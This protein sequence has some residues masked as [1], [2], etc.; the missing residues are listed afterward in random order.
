MRTGVV[1][2][3]LAWCAPFQHTT[4]F[5]FPIRIASTGRPIAVRAMVSTCKKGYRAC[6]P[7]RQIR[8]SP[9]E[10]GTSVG[11]TE[12]GSGIVTNSPTGRRLG[13]I[14]GLAAKICFTVVPNR[15]A[16]LKKVSPFSI[17]QTR[18]P[19]RYGNSASMVSGSSFP[20]GTRLCPV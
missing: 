6:R 9:A 16:I 12:N 19:Y 14:C 17:R 5:P 15:W 10:N 11:T 1:I 13:A 18:Y 3:S 20:V 8:S 2:H 7:R 4:R